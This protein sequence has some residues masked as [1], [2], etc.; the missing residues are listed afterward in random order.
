[1]TVTPGTE[2]VLAHGVGGGRDLPIPFQY[3]VIGAAWALVISFA[4]LAFAWRTSRFRG[5]DSGVPV[6]RWTA[7]VVDSPWTHAVVRLVVLAFTALFLVA[8]LF[9]PDL[10]TNPVFGMFYVFVW[11]GIVPASLLFGRIWRLASPLRLLHTGL[12]RLMRTDPDEGLFRIPGWVGLWPGALG[13][14]SFVW[15]ELVYPQSTYL[16]AVRGWIGLYTAIL[17]IGAVAFGRTWFAQA[18][19]FEV[20]SSLVARLSPFGR[21][22]DGAVVVRNPLENLDGMTPAPGLAAVVAVLFGSTG[23]DSFSQSPFWLTHAQSVDVDPVLLDSAVLVGFVLVVGLSFSVATMAVGGLGHIERARLPRLFAHSVVPIIVGYFVAHYLT[24]FVETGQQTLAQ[25][26]DPLGSGANLFGTTGMG[27]SY[28]LSLHPT[29]LAVTK[30][31]AVVVGHLLAAVS[32]HDRAVRVLPRGRELV[33][34]LPLLLV[35]VFY[36][37]AGLYL[38]LSS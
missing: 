33:G 2:I 25:M 3:A 28:V 37:S 12:S 20:F 19:P 23:F 11:V 15:L 16:V 17:L 18:D 32:A 34:Q 26:S 5:D 22:T 4:L 38:L 10:V 6:P 9:G 7:A 21:R 13:L 1:V 8:L 24:L 31:A 35:M 29:M 27:V 36:T 14:T 30:V